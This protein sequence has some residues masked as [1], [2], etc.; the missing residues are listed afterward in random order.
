MPNTDLEL[1]PCQAK[2]GA[3]GSEADLGETE[4][5]VR[6][7]WTTDVA[8][9]LTDQFGSQPQDQVITGQGARITVP[10]AEFTVAHMGL[11]LNQSLVGGVLVEGDRLVGSKMSDKGQ[12]L[13]LKAYVD[14]AVSELPADW[15]RFPIAA[16]VGSPEIAFSKADQRIIEIEFIAFPDVLNILYYIGDEAAS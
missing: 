14:G 10:L 6:V 8:D 2:W 5:G 7:V 12:S 3:A 16:P 11:A 15:I 9:L 1:G 4:G 13:L